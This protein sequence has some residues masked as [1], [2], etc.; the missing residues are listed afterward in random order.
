V[1]AQAHAAA[2]QLLIDIITRINNH[3]SNNW[4]KTRVDTLTHPSGA[5]IRHHFASGQFTLTANYLDGQPPT[6]VSWDNRNT[7][8]L[9]TVDQTIEQLTFTAPAP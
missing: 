2:H 4:T 5:T 9:P 1:T 3:P 7:R 8:P 6:V